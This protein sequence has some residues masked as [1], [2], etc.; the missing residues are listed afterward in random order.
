[1]IVSRNCWFGPARVAI[2][3]FGVGLF[4]GCIQSAPTPKPAQPGQSATTEVGSSKPVNAAPAE[5]ALINVE[6]SSTVYLI[7]QAFAVEFERSTPHKVKVSRNGTGGGYKNFA[8]RQCDLWNASRP[9]AEKE[10]AELKEKGIEWLE[11][12]VGIDGL[13]IA[14]HP[15]NDWCPGLSVAD[16]RKLWQ[17]DS[18]IAKWSDLNPQWPDQPFQL[19]G[20]DTDSGTFE[21]FTEVIVGK[22]NSSRTDYTPAS[23]DNIL[24]QGVSGNKFALGY[25]PHGYCEENK[26]RV[27]VIGVSPT[28]DAAETVAPFVMPTTETILSGEYAPLSRPL[29]VYVNKEALKRSEVAEFLKFSISKAAQPLVA[30]RGFVR[31]TDATRQE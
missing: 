10:I 5:E 13:S 9:I 24:I 30:K 2:C 11:L 6:G 12:T 17:P 16:L 28:K 22:K 31:M 8:L 27:K 23:D 21:Y 20:A 1:M 29:F 3:L 14:V 26:D 4:G 25:I 15:D 7:S 19:F 18:K